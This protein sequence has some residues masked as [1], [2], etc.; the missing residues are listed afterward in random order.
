VKQLPK[1]GK[2]G[3][4]S[5]NPEGFVDHAGHRAQL[6]FDALHV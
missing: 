3:I 2:V 4:P 1:R 5:Q 6:L